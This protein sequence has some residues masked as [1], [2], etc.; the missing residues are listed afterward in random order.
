MT[1][2]P[3]RTLNTMSDAIALSSPCGRMSKR[4]RAA[5]EKRLSEALFGPGGL[6][7]EKLMGKAPEWTPQQRAEHLRGLAKLANKSQA[8][9]LLAEA[10]SLVSDFTRIRT[11]A[12]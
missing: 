10:E 12:L 1:T 3:P 6:T 5:A 11:E 9:K 8:K 4:A 2:L 7:R